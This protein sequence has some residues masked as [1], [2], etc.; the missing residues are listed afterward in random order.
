MKRKADVRKE[1]MI[2]EYIKRIQN[3]ID[4]KKSG[5]QTINILKKIIEENV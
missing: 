5:D 1:E 2:N 4:S 3:Q